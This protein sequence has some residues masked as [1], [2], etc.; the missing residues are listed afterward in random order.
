MT[1]QTLDLA[2]LDYYGYLVRLLKTSHRMRYARPTLFNVLKRT[3]QL[4]KLR[5]LASEV[6]SS[7]HSEFLSDLLKQ[8]RTSDRPWQ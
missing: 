6:W 7:L 2:S 1:E 3:L 8:R 5:G 4:I